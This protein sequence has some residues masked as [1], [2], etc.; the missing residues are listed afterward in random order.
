LVRETVQVSYTLVFLSERQYQLQTGSLI[1]ETVQV[2][3]RLVVSSERQY[4]S[5]TGL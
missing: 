1:R 4:R 5:V 3:Y 2:S